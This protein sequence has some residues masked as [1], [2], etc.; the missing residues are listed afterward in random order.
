MGGRLYYKRSKCAFG[1]PYVEILGHVVSLKGTHARA[2]QGGSIGGT[3]TRE[4]RR[5]L[6]TTNY[7][8]QD[9]YVL[10]NPLPS[11]V[12]TPVAEW[13]NDDMA[14]AP[15]ELKTAVTE[16]LL[17]AHLDYSVPLVLQ[18]DASTLAPGHA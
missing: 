11:D 7:M 5:F 8:R 4:L 12:N 3:T 18:S 16:Q 14:E 13:Q 2:A 9:H 17:L 15:R 6:G 1:L 10:A